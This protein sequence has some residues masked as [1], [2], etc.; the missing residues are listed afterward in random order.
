MTL[1]EIST[2]ELHFKKKIDDQVGRIIGPSHEFGQN[3]VYYAVVEQE[4]DTNT[5][6]TT[7]GLA[8]HSHA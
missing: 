7:L 8:L 5:G 2:Y 1:S 6:I 4:W 3:G